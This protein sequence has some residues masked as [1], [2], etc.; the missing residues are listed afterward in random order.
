MQT[1]TLQH[2]VLDRDPRFTGLYSRGDRSFPVQLG[3]GEELDLCTHFN[4]VPTGKITQFT[5]V[6]DFSLVLDFDGEI[7]VTCRRLNDGSVKTQTLEM[8]CNV[9]AEF[10]YS[11]S[12]LVGFVLHAGPSGCMLRS[13][14]V[15]A[16]AEKVKQVY[17]ALVICTYRKED[18]VREKITRLRSAGICECVK[19][20][21]VDNGR[22]IDTLGENVTVVHSPNYGGSS[23]YTRGMI[24]CLDD[25]NITH[26]ILNDDDA[27]LDPEVIFRTGSFY[28]LIS[29][30]KED[31]VLGGTMLLAEKP[32]IVH[33]S[34]ATFNSVCVESLCHDLDISKESGNLA[35]SSDR[36][37]EHFGWWYF[38]VPSRV[39]RKIGLPLPMFLKYDDME[40]GLR[41]DSPKVTL[42]GVS[43]WHPG[44]RSKFSEMSAYYSFRN[45]LVAGSAHR[46]LPKEYLYLLLRDIEIDIAGYRYLNAETRLKAVDDFLKGPDSLF[47]MCRNGPMATKEFTTSDA[48]SL[49]KGLDLIGHVPEGNHTLRALSLNGLFRRPAGDVVLDFFE[50]RTSEF[51]RAG[52]ILYT[53]D[54]GSGIICARDRKMSM[55]LLFRTLKMR[56]VLMFR[57]NRMSRRYAESF[58]DYSSEKF[59]KELLELKK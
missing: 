6:E 42:C 3:P 36:D 15:T 32:N 14:K 8:E 48:E 20:I 54:D 12:K 59:W 55:R 22:T 10:D 24:E 9:P 46:R 1:V 2:L 57:Y 18:V 52:K 25:E 39:V 49:K 41:I 5:S 43:V 30:D 28:S 53:F 11:D 58:G 7:T 33:E 4:Y 27:E 19:I 23:G 29:D 31:A 34:G 35:L 56:I 21:V 37:T 40:Y 17:P 50:P 38:A 47:R 44:F 45:I 51:Y 13:G 16:R 26:I